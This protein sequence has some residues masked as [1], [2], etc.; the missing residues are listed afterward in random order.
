MAGRL[1]RQSDQP[2]SSKY[3]AL[4]RWQLKVT[5]LSWILLNVLLPAL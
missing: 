1:V 2:Y 5:E 4:L 3:F